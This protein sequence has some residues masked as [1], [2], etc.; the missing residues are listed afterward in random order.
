MTFTSLTFIAF[1]FTTLFLYWSAPNRKIQNGLLA[2]ASFTFYAWWDWR[3]YF[4]MAGCC[5]VNYSCA[6]KI[7][8]SQEHA[9]K[10]LA[11][12]LITSLGTLAYFKYFNFFLES[13]NSLAYQF[14]ASSHFEP[15]KILLPIA[16]SFYTFQCVAY[17]VDVYRKRLAASHS[18]LDFLTFA[19]FFP[20]LVAGPIERAEQ[21]LTQI[22]NNRRFSDSL[23]NEGMRQLLW[24]FTKKL[25]IAD[26]LAVVAN[27][28]FTEPRA[29]SSTHLVIGILA[30]S[31]QIYADFSAYSDIAIGCAKT[32]GIRL[33]RNF[34]FPYFSQRLDE[35][36]RR[37]HITLSYW[38]RDY[39]F[40]PL[41][42]LKGMGLL[43]PLFLTF[44]IS[45]LW[46]G[47]SWNFVIWGV[48]HGV[49]VGV[50]YLLPRPAERLSAEDVPFSRG[51]SFKG[52]V[53]MAVT[54][55]YVCLGWIFFRASSLS[56][57]WYILTHLLPGSTSA[58]KTFAG[59]GG[60][61]V[62]LLSVSLLSIEWITRGFR[63]PLESLPVPR[64]ARWCLY[65]LIMSSILVW[66]S[67]G[68]A[69]TF[70][71]FQF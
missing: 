49:G 47:A 29:Y 65:I 3:L 28:V 63:H 16:I 58:T 30:F 25:L 54:F 12:G 20:Q 66:G 51:L 11:V 36:W 68:S 59:V 62:L 6:I 56:D 42:Q 34:A 31:I 23:A 21:L 61:Q 38:F 40:E 9:R 55:S 7:E 44:A 70:I 48:I 37:W 57:A 13:L 45:G 2:I 60:V 27:A 26:N 14:E 24:G 39:F 50:L 33:S 41:R 5:A 4:L 43:V 64:L 71:Y 8:Q 69:N 53:S 35:F 19:T 22:Q 10:W 15:H 1:F 52:L 67:F 32:F 18:F 17:T 46:H